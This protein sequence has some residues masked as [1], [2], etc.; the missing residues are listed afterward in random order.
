MAI[1]NI[2][3]GSV[4]D[5]ISASLIANQY[6]ESRYN[7]LGSGSIDASIFDSIANVSASSYFDF[8]YMSA[9]LPDYDCN[10]SSWSTYDTLQHDT[11][12][13]FTITSSV[14]GG[15]VEPGGGGGVEP[16]RYKMRGWYTLGNSYEYWI[17]TDPNSLP[18]TG[19]TLLDVTIA[20][21]LT[22]K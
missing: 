2:I 11:I 12:S 9:S 5:Y 19:H 1:I 13:Y 10:Y 20:Q 6:A 3:S 17:T 14:G 7:A 22:N 18:P 15:G 8:S 21:V 4:F 16:L